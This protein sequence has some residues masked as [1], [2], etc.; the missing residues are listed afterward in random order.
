MVYRECVVGYWQHGTPHGREDHANHVLLDAL[1]GQPSSWSLEYSHW[2]DLKTMI[3]E[4]YD[5]LGRFHQNTAHL[6]MVNHQ[7]LTPDY[8]VQCS[9]LE[10]GTKVWVNFGI[11]TYHSGEIDLPPKSLRMARPGENPITALVSREIQYL[12]R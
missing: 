11:T 9:E 8:M 6:A 3:A 12:D 5:L 2:G 4:T 1:Y 7:F 10:D